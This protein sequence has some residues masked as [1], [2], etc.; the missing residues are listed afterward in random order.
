[1]LMSVDR[2]A[3]VH[4]GF[5]YSL[6]HPKKRKMDW[7]L[8]A[9]QEFGIY[10]VMFFSFFSSSRALGLRRTPS[11]MAPFGGGGEKMDP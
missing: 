2:L 11:H 1:M 10:S 4:A 3:S 6:K 5:L 8:A 9:L 7:V